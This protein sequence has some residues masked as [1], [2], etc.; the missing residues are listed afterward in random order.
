MKIFLS[1]LI[2]TLCLAALIPVSAQTAAEITEI[3]LRND[4]GFGFDRGT[5][6]KFFSDGSAEYSGGRNAFGLKGKYRG[7]IG[8]SAFARLANLIVRQEFFAFKDRYETAA[9]DAATITTTVVYKGGQ[10]SVAN[11]ANSGGKKILTIERAVQALEIKV[12][13]EKVK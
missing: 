9:N 6:V 4:G 11:F 1:I 8:K 2:L 7:Q 3:K 12:K 13:W 5:E 10:K